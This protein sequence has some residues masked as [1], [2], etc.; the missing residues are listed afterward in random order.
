MCLD[1]APQGGVAVA[2]SCF[3]GNLTTKMYNVLGPTVSRSLVTMNKFNP[4]TQQPNLSSFWNVSFSF[5]EI[6]SF[7]NFYVIHYFRF[8]YTLWKK[9]PH[10]IS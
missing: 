5:D 4:F 6:L 9:L 7:S 8:A 1:V 3:Y 2:Y 10:E